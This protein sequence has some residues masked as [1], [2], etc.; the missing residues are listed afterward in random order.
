MIALN[1]RDLEKERTR[2]FEGA[3]RRGAGEGNRSGT[4]HRT[5]R[6]N[7]SMK[8]TLKRRARFQILAG[9]ALALV[10]TLSLGACAPAAWQK[11][12]AAEPGVVA[13]TMAV[14]GEVRVRRVPWERVEVALEAERA[15][16]VASDV[17]EDQWPAGQREQL[18]ELLLRQL[19]FSSPGAV[20]LVGRSR[21]VTADFEELDAR[22]LTSWARRV[23]AETV[24]YASRGMG[25]AER[26]DREWVFYDRF[27]GGRYYD[28]GS[29][30]AIF[31]GRTAASVPVVRSVP[32]Y[33]FVVYWVRAR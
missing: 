16:A 22:E 18:T 5:V 7:P 24:V 20:E 27:D 4:R 28:T 3:A 30:H 23:N 8:S 1:L 26:V 19:Q 14:E 13:G 33:E 15:A 21:F 29:R 10:G 6:N 12:Y 2:G 25:V 32:Q 31:P 9:P 17:P 11:A